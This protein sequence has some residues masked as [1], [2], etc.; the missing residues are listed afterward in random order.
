MTRSHRKVPGGSRRWSR[1]RDLDQRPDDGHP[2]RGPCGPRVPRGGG[3]DRR[4]RPRGGPRCQSPGLRGRIPAI[5][6]RARLP[7]APRPSCPAA[8]AGSSTSPAPRPGSTVGSTGP[9]SAGSTPELELDLSPAWFPEAGPDPGPGR[10]GRVASVHSSASGATRLRVMLSAAVQAR[11]ELDAEHPDELDRPRRSRSPWNFPASA[12]VGAS[13]RQRGVASVGQR[14]HGAPPHPGPGLSWI[15]PKD[16]P[17]LPFAV[18][19]H[20]PA[21]VPGLAMDG[22]TGR[23][24]HLDREHVGRTRWPRS[25]ARGQ[26]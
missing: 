12:P 23:G 21:G 7:R 4:L 24:R 2:R 6:R 14:R 1:R 9:S 10:S 25:A 13:D 22:R 15:D 3:P 5:G 26:D 11:E 8:S 17:G 18:S 20:Q 16:V 19:R